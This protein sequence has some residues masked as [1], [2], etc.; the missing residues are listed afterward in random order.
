MK[1]PWCLAMAFA[2]IVQ[3]VTQW[4]WSDAAKTKEQA[5]ANAAEAQKA[6]IAGKKLIT[7]WW[8][9]R[10][11]DTALIPENLRNPKVRHWTPKNSAAD[12]WPFMVIAAR[13]VD[14]SFFD[15]ECLKTLADEQRLTNRVRRLPDDFDLLANRFVSP[16]VDLTRI[17]FGSAEYAKDGLI[18]ITEILGTDTPYFQRMRDL[19]DDIL[20]ESRVETRFGPIPAS[21]HEVNGDMLQVLS[22]LWWATRDDRYMEMGARIA[23][24]FLLD[25]PPAK[26]DRLR[27]RD[28]GGEII[29]GLCEFYVAAKH[30]R[31]D[32]AA[33]LREP[34]VS[35]LDRILQI[36]RN[37]DG[38]LYNEVNAATGEARDTKLADTWG[39]ILDGYYA[40][41]R[42]EGIS[43]YR[44]AVRKTL[45]N[46]D[47]YL[48]YDWERASADGMADALESAVTLLRWEPSDVGFAWCSHTYNKMLAIQ[49]PSGIIEGW[50]G[51]GNSIRSALMWAFYLSQG[52][53]IEPWREDV[54]VGAAP[55]SGGLVVC[56]MADKDWKGRLCFD[57]PRHKDYLKMTLD[58]PR[59]NGFAEWFTANA[60][61]QY[62]V[63]RESY[64]GE[65]R[66]GKETSDIRSPLWVVSGDDLIR[67]I[68]IQVPAG[69]PA[70]LTIEQ[71]G[72]A[73]A[74]T[75]PARPALTEKQTITALLEAIS[76]SQNLTFIRN[77]KEYPTYAARQLMEGKLKKAG[78]P[79][80]TAENFIEQVGTRSSTTGRVYL[81]KFADGRTTE[82]AFWLR[83][84]LKE[85]EQGA[86]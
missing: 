12:N 54:A 39:Y 18:S 32:L 30:G 37:E 24:H 61:S 8:D 80:K 56:V 49:K 36:A 22:R 23:Q 79:V 40:I 33:R 41:Y 50:H 73:Q 69:K 26:A 82:S 65:E 46:L 25:A 45:G 42:V 81:I 27:L 76:K 68:E 64:G 72:V 9:L 29:N 59:I 44:D 14:R 86:R 48:D 2:C 3:T 55:T 4:S 75:E 38:L 17:I 19:T 77:D 1:Y 57:R 74:K 31:S 21:D 43:R 66:L 78:N 10:D 47:K 52:T 16:K 83:A 84:R 70:Y 7:G 5:R 35:N 58:Y 85:I 11:T 6:F 34:L 28:H 71:A 62:S 15:N 51:D 20:A 67:G 53:H 63:R 13:F 60:S